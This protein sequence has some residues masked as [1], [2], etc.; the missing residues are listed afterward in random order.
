MEEANPE[1]VQSRSRARAARSAVISTPS[2]WQL[3][4][5]IGSLPAIARS[6]LVLPEPLAP[7]R[8]CQR[9][10]L[11]P[12]DTPAIAWTRPRDTQRS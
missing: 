1:M 5:A 3:P 11:K 2:T 6:K 4:E 8:P 12:A 10:A 9:P 7:I